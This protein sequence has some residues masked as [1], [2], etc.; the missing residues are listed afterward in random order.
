MS[1][2]HF[3][4]VGIVAANKLLS[5]KVIEVTPIESVPMLDGEITDNVNQ[6]QT[7]SKDASG[8]TYSAAVATT[9]TVKATWLPIGSSNRI[10]APDV[11][12]GEIVI[13]Y[14]FAD[15]DEFYWGTLKDDSHLRKL[16]T[17]IFAFNADTVEGSKASLDN[18]YFLEISTHNKVVHFHTSNANGEPYTYDIQIN[19]GEGFIQIQDNDGNFIKFDSKEQQI[20]MVNKSGSKV[21]INK[22]DI[23]LVSTNSINLQTKTINTNVTTSV[24]NATQHTCT[25]TVTQNGDTTHNGN[26]AL[27]G[28]LATGGGGGGGNATIGGSMSVS[29]VISS[30]SA[31][32]ISISGADAGI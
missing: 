2:L 30:P 17:V 3:Y 8:A 31:A 11:R 28:N 26:L 27:N 18:T 6:Y 5:S 20:E 9:V 7:T 22:A 13:I 15:S 16:E 32:N 24:L 21:E 10:T 14:R 4:S 29:G 1:K 25:A 23:N 12:R 19:T